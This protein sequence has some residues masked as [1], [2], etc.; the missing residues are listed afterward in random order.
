MMEMDL[1]GSCL[2]EQGVKALPIEFGRG[3]KS[4]GASGLAVPA[5]SVPPSQVVAVL[6]QVGFPDASLPAES[7]TS[8]KFTLDL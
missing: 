3:C 6:R 4:V 5:P 7:G 1:G 8:V 2:R